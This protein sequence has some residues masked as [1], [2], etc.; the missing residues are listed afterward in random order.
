MKLKISQ[1]LPWRRK[2]RKVNQKLLL[3][4]CSFLLLTVPCHPSVRFPILTFLHLLCFCSKNIEYYLTR[5]GLGFFSTTVLLLP[6]SPTPFSFDLESV[7]SIL[8]GWEVAVFVLGCWKVWS[9]NFLVADDEEKK[10]MSL[11]CIKDGFNDMIK[12]PKWRGPWGLMW[13][14]KID[15][16]VSWYLVWWCL[17]WSFL[18]EIWKYSVI[19]SDFTVKKVEKRR[20]NGVLTCVC[21]NTSSCS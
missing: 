21:S 18:F 17:V 5:G 11:C 14:G 9:A 4:D 13:V 6:A 15:I 1:F 7:L 20:E 2:V 10:I 8:H 3:L 16:S 12:E 19:V